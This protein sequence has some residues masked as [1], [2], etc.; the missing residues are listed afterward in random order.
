M[1]LKM[2]SSTR[3]SK[4]ASRVEKPATSRRVGKNQLLGIIYSLESAI[5]KLNWR[6]AGTEW[7]DY[8]TDTNYSDAAMAQKRKVMAYRRL[9]LAQLGAQ[10]ANVPLSLGQ[11]QDHLQARGVAHVLEQD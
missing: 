1:I 2:A 4:H 8:Y 9:A 6:P 7:S 5:R 10:G 3:Q 11:N